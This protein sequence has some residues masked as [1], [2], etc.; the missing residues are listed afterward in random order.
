MKITE[1]DLLII[2]RFCLLLDKHNLSGC[3]Q[4]SFVWSKKSILPFGKE[5]EDQKNYFFFKLFFL[6][7]I[8]QFIFD[9]ER[10]SIE[11]KLRLLQYLPLFLTVDVL[12][13]V[14][15][16]FIGFELSKQNRHLKLNPY[17]FDLIKS[18]RKFDKVKLA[19]K[20][21]LHCF[22][23][24]LVTWNRLQKFE[25]NLQQW[26]GRHPNTHKK[27]AQY[28]FVFQ[29]DWYVFSYLPFLKTFW[30]GAVVRIL[31]YGL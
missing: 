13:S 7:D 31:D 20:H 30:T 27:S 8:K 25:W 28:G 9:L 15:P 18:I 10:S 17:P 23:L 26:N 16:Q 2:F 22:Q 6:F 19:K 11:K 1:R 12:I 21:S 4:N 5:Q 29:S 3:V 14:A 24:V